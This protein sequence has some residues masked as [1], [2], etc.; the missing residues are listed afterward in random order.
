LQIGTADLSEKHAGGPGGASAKAKASQREFFAHW[1]SA[2]P[3]IP[4]LKQ[5]KAE[6]EKLK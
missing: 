6:Y 5:A 3:D 1:Q 2:D 4:I